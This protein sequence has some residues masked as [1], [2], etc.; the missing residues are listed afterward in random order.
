MVGIEV[1]YNE[2]INVAENI[3]MIIFCKWLAVT[4]CKLLGADFWGIGYV[5]IYLIIC[6]MYLHSGNIITILLGYQ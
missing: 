3:F 6:D 5:V 1:Y 2:V 4:G